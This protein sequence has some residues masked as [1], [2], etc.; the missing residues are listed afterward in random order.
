[1]EPTP[2]VS[3]GGGLS[4]GAIAGIV[5]GVLLVVVLAVGGLY[6]Y[7]SSS[8]KSMPSV[9]MPSFPSTFGGSSSTKASL[10]K[11]APSGGFDNPM[12][13]GD[14]SLIYVLVLNEASKNKLYCRHNQFKS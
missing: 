5:I 14:V 12:S 13:L 4:G 11:P 6:Y 3:G 8:G 9:S 2:N 10:E 7:M 1:M